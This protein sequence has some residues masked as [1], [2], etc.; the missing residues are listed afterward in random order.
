MLSIPAGLTMILGK[1][2]KMLSLNVIPL[3]KRTEHIS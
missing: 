3:V 1:A 2:G